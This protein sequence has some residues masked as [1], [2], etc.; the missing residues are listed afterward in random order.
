MEQI[1]T[2]GPEECKALLA[3]TERIFGSPEHPADFAHMLPKIYRS[4]EKSAHHNLVLEEDGTILGMLLRL[5]TRLVAEDRTL[6]VGHI[7][8]VCVAPE[9]RGR[10]VM[11][12]LLNRAIEDLRA[13]GCALIVL[14]GQRQR[15]ERYGFIPTGVKTEF[16]MY[17]ANVRGASTDGYT[18]L[19]LEGPEALAGARRLFPQNGIYMQRAEEN[20]ADTLASW[21]AHP[22]M[23]YQNG[24]PAG[25]CTM[26]YWQ[27]GYSVL[28]ELRLGNAEAFMP[29]CSLLFRQG[30]TAL[31][32]CLAPGAPE[33]A[34]AFLLCER[35]IIGPDHS[36]HILRFSELT[37]ALLRRK[38][39]ISP[40]PCGVFSM[41]IEG[42]GG[43]ELYVGDGDAGAR[44]CPGNS[45]QAELS[46]Q[47]AV[48]L[49]FSSVSAERNRLAAEYPFLAAWLPLPLYLEQND[50]Y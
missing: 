40:L 41:N 15:Y 27:E 48:H 7:G 2:A 14:S 37:D 38:R 22:F 45:A 3:F 5:S 36:I 12:R 50:C 28:S 4:P 35:Y 6:L 49:L 16:V 13:E 26:F 39:A 30:H 42:H 20:F 19:P 11:G 34:P 46:C 1:R 29:L 43:L 23:L 18:L 47:Q 9:Y 21:D 10:G 31:K 8:S 32:I 44:S 33:Y 24:Q 17:E 25:Y